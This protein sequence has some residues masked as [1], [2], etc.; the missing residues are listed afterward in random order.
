[1]CTIYV[2]VPF[3]VLL[4]F[5]ATRIALG[6]TLTRV[7]LCHSVIPSHPLLATASAAITMSRN[8]IEEVDDVIEEVEGKEG[9]EE[10]EEVDEGIFAL[11]STF[12]D[13]LNDRSIRCVS[14]RSV[15]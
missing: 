14:N 9:E 15:R 8:Q 2:H 7:C 3:I 6:L 5:I 12:A 10:V 11:P 1:M 4:F 13:L